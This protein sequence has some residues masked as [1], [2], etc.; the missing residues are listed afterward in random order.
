MTGVMILTSIPFFPPL[1]VGWVLEV[2]HS[3]IGSWSVLIDMTLPGIGCCRP[4]EG[5]LAA[6]N[7]GWHGKSQLLL[8][9]ELHILS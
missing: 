8:L 2:P 3:P 6:G 7:D 1:T 9:S 5:S 4:S